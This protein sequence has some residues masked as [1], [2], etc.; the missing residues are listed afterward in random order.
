MT[1]EEFSKE[2]HRLITNYGE[3][4]YSPERQEIL[5]KYFK[6][7]IYKAFHEGISKLIADC[8][9]AP[10]NSKIAEAYGEARNNL[11]ADAGPKPFVDENNKHC[12]FC[13]GTGAINAKKRDGNMA[14]FAFKCGQCKANETLGHYKGLP[15]WDETFHSLKYE[16]LPPPFV[17]MP[18]AIRKKKPNVDALIADL[19]RGVK[20]L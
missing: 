13:A 4:H 2:I 19:T 9:Q 6:N 8:A 14:T 16:R 10:L 5:W 11:Q 12:K 15:E 1:K 3:K 7:A 17:G 18:L 20:S